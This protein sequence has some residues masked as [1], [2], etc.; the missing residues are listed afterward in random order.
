MHY[1]KQRGQSGS[2]AENEWTWVAF[3]AKAFS[4]G[5]T[6]FPCS[7]SSL[8]GRIEATKSRSFMQDEYL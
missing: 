6:V 2:L 3:Y 8:L 7:A 4:V 5:S 1:Q